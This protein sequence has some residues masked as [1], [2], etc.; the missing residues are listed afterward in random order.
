MQSASR[1]SIYQKSCACHF[2]PVMIGRR[3]KIILG[4]PIQREKATFHCFAILSFDEPS[5][6]DFST[7]SSKFILYKQILQLHHLQIN[8]LFTGSTYHTIV[9]VFGEGGFKSSLIGGPPFG[10]FVFFVLINM[11]SFLVSSRDL[12]P[13]YRILRE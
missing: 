9:L 2:P 8:P 3:S 5:R 7:I 13:L 12:L 1:D 4:I 10:L 11:T 6:P